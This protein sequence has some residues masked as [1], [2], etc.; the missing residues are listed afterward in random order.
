MTAMRTP[1]LMS[2]NVGLPRNVHGHGG[3]QRA[4]L[5]YQIQSDITWS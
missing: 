3:E 2:V 1:V 5:V 4:V